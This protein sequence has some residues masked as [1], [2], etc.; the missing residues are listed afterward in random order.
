MKALSARAAVLRLQWMTL[1]WMILEFGMALASG[2]KAKSIAL[3]AFGGDS[4]IELLSAAIVLRRFYLGEHEEDRTARRAAALLS[5][6]AVFIVVSSMA[7]LAGVV[8][9]ARPSWAGMALLAASAAVMPWLGR[10]KRAL[11]AKA[12]SASLRAD[13][14]QSSVCGSLAWIA[15]AGLVLNALWGLAWADSA[16]ALLL[17]PLVLNEARETRRGKCCCG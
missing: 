2:L 1:A 3:L 14:A 16:A 13:A 11:A 8:P 7:A 9:H 12:G 15:L 17:V 4:A 6:L 10:K 5:L